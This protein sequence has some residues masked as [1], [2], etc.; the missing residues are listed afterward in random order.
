[1]ESN[2]PKNSPNGVQT[3]KIH[4]KKN[5]IMHEAAAGGGTAET[6]VHARVT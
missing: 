4:V 3:E 1:M 5:N 2:E 6:R